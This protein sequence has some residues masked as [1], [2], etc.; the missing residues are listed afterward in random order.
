MV[1]SRSV[2]E[3]H[4]DQGA[5]P[6]HSAMAFGLRGAAL[7]VTSA[8]RLG[9]LA[10]L[11]PGRRLVESSGATAPLSLPDPLDRPRNE[12]TRNAP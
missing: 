3:T 11:I 6:L 2:S 5:T 1:R 7:V 8:A 12:Y 9:H 10:E 4:P